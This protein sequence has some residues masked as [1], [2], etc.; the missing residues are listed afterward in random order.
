MW[1][2]ALP[3]LSEQ[4]QE[5]RDRLSLVAEWPYRPSLLVQLDQRA[6]FGESVEPQPIRLYRV[7]PVSGGR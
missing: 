4:P 5:I 1:L 3:P 7:T 2:T 6:T